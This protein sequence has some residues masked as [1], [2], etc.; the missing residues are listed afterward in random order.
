MNSYLHTYMLRLGSVKLLVSSVY[1]PISSWVLMELDA[2]A[3]L[4]DRPMITCNRPSTSFGLASNN[5]TMPF[6]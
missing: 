6:Y 3:I 5:T 4:L 2:L 1:L